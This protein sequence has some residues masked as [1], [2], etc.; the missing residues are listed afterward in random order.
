[1]P[2]NN[3]KTDDRIR[4][5]TNPEDLP[6]SATYSY[7]RENT[8]YSK[9]RATCYWPHIK[10]KKHKVTPQA[11]CLVLLFSVLA[12]FV[13]PYTL[14]CRGFRYRLHLSWTE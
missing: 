13:C 8:Y 10:N 14:S 6:S 9:D 4:E 5:Y 2:S 1:M 11:V 7:V 12:S 3:I